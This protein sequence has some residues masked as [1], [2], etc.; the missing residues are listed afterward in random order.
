MSSTLAGKKCRPCE[1]GEEPLRGDALSKLHAQLA[2]GWDVIDEHHL[3]KSYKFKNFREAL[4]FTNRVGEVAEAEGHHPDIY[5]SWG[6]V[7]LKVWTHKIDGLT[8]SDFIFAAK[9]DEAG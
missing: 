5:L 3:Q 7:E 4:D 2:E 9:A 8:G 6:K 1:G